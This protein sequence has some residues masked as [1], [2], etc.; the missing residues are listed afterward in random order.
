LAQR[1]EVH[2]SLF[3]TCIVDQLYPQVGVSAV[4]VLRKH[5]VVVDFPQDQTC[6]GQPL[7]NSGFTRKA[8]Q[9]ARRV[10]HSFS[11]SDYVVVPSGSCA[12]MLKVFYLELCAGDP[13]LEELAAQLAG[14][15][16][17]FSEFLVKVLKVDDAGA[18]FPAR[19]AFHSGCHLL[20]EME[21]RRE[22]LQLLEQVDGLELVPLPQADTCCGFGGTFS[23]K[24]PHISQGMMDDK[25]NSVLSTGVDTLVS[26]DMSC[27]MHI[28]GGLSRQGHQVGVR[29]IAEVLEGLPG[30]GGHS[31]G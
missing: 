20:R 26:C 13:E 29:H 15:V 22:P 27:L 2:A 17:E 10:L 25:I 3:V 31:N 21:V 6:C 7:Y 12:A 30:E 11:L 24:Y 16:Y 4:K 14:K 1:D 9:L 5:G 23:V 19:A 28:G 18:H 8:R